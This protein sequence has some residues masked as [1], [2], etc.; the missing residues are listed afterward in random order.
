LFEWWYAYDAYAHKI[1]NT[2]GAI[3]ATSGFAGCGA[4]VI[5]SL[6][7]ARQSK[8]VTT[9]GSSRWA[10]G[11]EIEKAGLFQSSGVFLG[12][13]DQ[14]YLRHDGPEHVM[15]F[16]PTRSGKGVGL[17]IPTLLSWTHS[18][19]IHDIKGEN[20]QLTA[21]W[22]SQFS[23]CLLFNPTDTRIR[24]ASAAPA[25]STAAQPPSSPAPTP[26][27]S[28]GSSAPPDWAR[29]MQRGQR[30]AGHT[31]AITQA[32]KEGDRPGHGANPEL[33]GGEG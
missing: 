24:A 1:F 23:F 31:R 28:P 29:R 22:R 10:N 14:R 33:D 8:N 5:G 30:T 6:W 11:K 17:V 13:L 7:R 15:A 3:A 25:A 12:Q 9:Y 27:V 18:V 32:I 26:P 19:I 16:A 20:W 4:A 21:G 2:A